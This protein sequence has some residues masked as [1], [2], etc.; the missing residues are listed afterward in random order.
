MGQTWTWACV[1]AGG[2]TDVSLRLW[3]Q[4]DC[5]P[6]W[7]QDG[8]SLGP[9]RALHRHL[10]GLGLRPRPGGARRA[11]GQHPAG[12]QQRSRLPGAPVTGEPVEHRADGDRLHGPVERRRP[13]RRADRLRRPGARWRRPG[14]WA[15]W[16]TGTTGTSASFHGQATATP[17]PFAA[18]H[19][20]SWAASKTGLPTTGKTPSPPCWLEPAPVLITS[21]Q[22]GLSRCACSPAT[23]SSSRSTWTT[24]ATWRLTSRLT[25]PLPANLT[26]TAG[27]WISPDL[28]PPTLSAAPSPGTAPWPPAR[29]ASPSALRPR[30]WTSNRARQIV[31]IAG[32]DDGQSVLHRRATIR[33]CVRLYLPLVVKQA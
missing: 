19:G 23:W 18:A 27:P 8:L 7:R 28:P 21:G 20:T 16:L 33:R 24:P 15:D 9:G 30:C 32:I 11:G 6:L 25:D 22:G 31:N 1:L 26:V 3:R 12:P 5:T 29:P 13:R 2:G 17:T 10:A 4:A 14:P